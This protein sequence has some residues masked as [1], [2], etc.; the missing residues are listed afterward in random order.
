MARTQPTS[1]IVEARLVTDDEN[2]Q[3]YEYQCPKCQS[4]H[5][6]SVAYP[7]L[8]C[9]N[10]SCNHSF[11]IAYPGLGDLSPHEH[12]PVI[13]VEDAEE[14]YRKWKNLQIHELHSHTDIPLKHKTGSGLPI[15]Q[16]KRDYIT[17]AV[18]GRHGEDQ[19]RI[20]KVGL[21]WVNTLLA[22]NA[23]YGSTVWDSPKLAPYVNPGIAI[24]TRMSDKIDRLINLSKKNGPQVHTESFDDTISDLGAYCLLY[25]ARPNREK[26]MT[27]DEVI[28]T[29][30]ENTSPLKFEPQGEEKMYPGRAGGGMADP[31]YQR[32]LE[33]AETH[34]EVRTHEGF[35]PRSSS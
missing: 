19:Q 8:Y 21:D 29:F 24:L 3:V 30:M 14:A 27:P 17:E 31:D 2:D 23:D 11:G 5:R 6:E 32:P 4:V 18:M 34:D 20:A 10:S 35:K 12:P 1:N 25:L 26:P 33:E 7:N 16:D 22:K 15:E 28:K 13:T 9:Q